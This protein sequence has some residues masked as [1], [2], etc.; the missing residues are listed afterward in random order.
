MVAEY[1]L[2][3]VTWGS[4]V[5]SPILPTELEEHLPPL[6]CYLPPEDEMGA[7]D[8][9]VR[10]H[11][12]RTL[13]VAMW[14]HHLDMAVSDPNSSWSLIKA[15]HPMGV[16]LAYFLGPGMAW[17]LTFEDVIARVLKENRELFDT[18][19][20]EAVASLHHCN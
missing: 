7:M 11:R 20:N 3:C 5:T 16:L 19:R 12:A 1:H 15:C 17:Q 4:T 10:D 9:R 14:C 2:A 18:R 13:R 6:A 8:I